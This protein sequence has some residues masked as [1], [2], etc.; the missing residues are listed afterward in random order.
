MIVALIITEHGFY[1]DFEPTSDDGSAQTRLLSIVTARTGTNAARVDPQLT[2]I[3][4]K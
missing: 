3:A 1:D 4:R 2:N